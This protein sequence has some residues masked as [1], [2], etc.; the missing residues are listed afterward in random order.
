MGLTYKQIAALDALLKDIDVSDAKGQIEPGSY[1]VDFTIRVIGGFKK[2]CDTT[3]K[4][5][6]SIPW[7]TT[8]ALFVHRSGMQRDKAMDILKH[9]MID[10]LNFDKD[11]E[12]EILKVSGVSDARDLLVDEVLSKLPRTPVKGAVIGDV[13]VEVL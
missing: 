5:S 8:L 3:K 12:K 1:D 6:S 11:A 7:I 2:L 4:P 9:A 13:E 10:A